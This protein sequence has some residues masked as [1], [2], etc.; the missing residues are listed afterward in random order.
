MAQP[1]AAY[2]QPMQLLVWHSLPYSHHLY[3][4]LSWSA[5]Y[6]RL[7]FCWKPAGGMHAH[8]ALRHRQGNI[9]LERSAGSLIA[10]PACADKHTANNVCRHIICAKAFQICWGR[11]GETANLLLRTAGKQLPH[12]NCRGPGLVLQPLSHQ[13]EHHISSAR[14]KPTLLRSLTSNPQRT[15]MP[16]ERMPCGTKTPVR[17]GS[18]AGSEVRAHADRHSAV[19]IDGH[20]PS[21]SRAERRQAA[22]PHQKV[23]LPRIP[24]HGQQ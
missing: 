18:T 14:H 13:I 17:H 15:G 19:L 11:R 20:S 5:L 2:S 23:P 22:H 8:D 4:C 21:T 24:R 12:S 3:P 6:E 1:H 9:A 16:G 10:G 7:R